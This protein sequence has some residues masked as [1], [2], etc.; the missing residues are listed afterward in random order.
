MN[1]FRGLIANAKPGQQQQPDP[2]ADQV[3]HPRPPAP[4]ASQ[5]HS[6]LVNSV[7]EWSAVSGAPNSTTRLP[8]PPTPST[9]R[10]GSASTG[11]SAASRPASAQL[12]AAKA[13]DAEDAVAAL[14]KYV[15]SCGGEI[16][17]ASGV[18]DFYK[19]AKHDG[20]AFKEALRSLGSKKAEVYARHGLVLER[21]DVGSDMIKLI[22]HGRG[23][24]P[25]LFDAVQV[26]ESCR[27]KA[28]GRTD[29]GGVFYCNSCWKSWTKV[30]VELTLT[31]SGGGSGG[32]VPPVAGSAVVT[33]TV[34]T[35]PLSSSGLQHSTPS[36]AM[37]KYVSELLAARGPCIPGTAFKQ[38]FREHHGFELD[39]GKGK[40]Q[41]FL[42]LY[43]GVCKLQMQP[44]PNGPS[45]LFVYAV[46]DDEL[47][48]P[49][50]SKTLEAAP[51]VDLVART[52]RQQKAE[53][54]TR[55]KEAKEQEQA[56]RS[57]RAADQRQAQQQQQ[58]IRASQQA[59]VPKADDV[60]R[61]FFDKAVKTET[62]TFKNVEAAERF[63]EALETYADGDLPWRL[64]RLDEYGLK[65]M[66]D[67]AQMAGADATMAMVRALM[68][69][70]Y[71]EDKFTPAL[72]T[73]VRELFAAHSLLELITRSVERF[74]QSSKTLSALVDFGLTITNALGPARLHKG[75]G[76]RL[77]GNLAAALIGKC[78][79][80]VAERPESTGAR[81]ALQGA[82]NLRNV[83]DRELSS[84]NHMR[85]VEAQV[86][87]AADRRHA[88][89]ITQLPGGRHSNDYVD[90]RQ[91]SIVPTV[92]ELSPS[93]IP[94]LPRVD[95]VETFLAEDKQTQLLD[96]QF[97]L[98]REDMIRSVRDALGKGVPFYLPVALVGLEDHG[99]RRRVR[100]Q[101]R[102]RDQRQDGDD[103]LKM[104]MGYQRGP[105]GL[106]F[107]IE[108]GAKDRLPRGLA[109][110][111][112]L[113]RRRLL[114]VGS[115]ALLRDGDQN[116]AIGRVV[117]ALR[118]ATEENPTSDQQIG[119]SFDDEN[120]VQLLENKKCRNSRREVCTF[121]LK[122]RCK[123][124]DQCQFLHESKTFQLVPI[125]G[126]FFA[127]E[128]VL[129]CLQKIRE[130]PFCEELLLQK[131][132]PAPPTYH[133]TPELRRPQPQNVMEQLG[134]WRVD[135]SN[136]RTVPCFHTP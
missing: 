84:A 124:G 55:A 61:P 97:R 35:G 136:L 75:V 132:V 33:A 128:P 7:G 92:D 77:L 76:G 18:A 32:L 89:H 39:L 2:Q 71:K 51:E 47:R 108:D 62:F 95:R 121:F 50:H 119:I 133:A 129:K 6:V 64:T 120:L 10:S 67:A 1:F 56:K 16:S 135:A 102:D 59:A 58:P 17:A 82:Q 80:L 85:K 13:H 57:Q 21:R 115:L 15:E 29:T 41:D 126:S 74:E 105:S 118:E 5:S 91:I 96:R 112:L 30:D 110:I 98:L 14:Y 40:L 113:S 99:Y 23:A 44:M 27:S 3:P 12:P 81:K 87:A 69:P 117:K 72:E 90:F 19:G 114:Q 36:P 42:K 106:R 88:A 9:L 86:A 46:G 93:Q 28:G 78:R 100:D 123:Y 37:A 48:P 4:V 125:P 70:Q 68:Q 130:L 83:L 73:C 43:E 45:N 134:E 104:E 122:G 8:S 60:N 131:K 52:L 49:P 109:L 63:A 25:G 54:E 101:R 11:S 66:V 127:Y 31:A 38:Y 24:R 94:F 116:I 111:E 20:D 53:D 103:T 79:D 65:R 26:C 34:P 107:E 22:D